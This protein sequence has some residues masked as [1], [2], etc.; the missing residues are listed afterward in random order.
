MIFNRVNY[1]V[2]EMHFTIIIFVALISLNLIGIVARI[3]SISSDHFFYYQSVNCQL[4]AAWP[5]WLCVCG[6]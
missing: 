4:A 3:D 2:V 1:T 6:Q 5:I